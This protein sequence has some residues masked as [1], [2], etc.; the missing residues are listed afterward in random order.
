MHITPQT[1]AGPVP[2]ELGIPLGAGLPFIAR[3]IQADLAAKGL[4]EVLTEE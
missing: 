3:I 1:L 4:D 2:A